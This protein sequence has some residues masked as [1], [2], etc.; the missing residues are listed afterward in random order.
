MYEN[1]DTV[2]H[3]NESLL[4]SHKTNNQQKN[5]GVFT[6]SLEMRVAITNI[7]RFHQKYEYIHIVS[8]IIVLE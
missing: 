5:I 6:P 1:I 8:I 3:C 2:K 7:T 4:I